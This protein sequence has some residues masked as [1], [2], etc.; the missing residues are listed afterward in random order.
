MKHVICPICGSICIK[1]GKNK[2]GTQRWYCNK[3][4]SSVTPQIDNSAKQLQIFLNWLFSSKTQKEMP[5][6]GRSF[7]RKTAG[8]W[9]IWPLPPL[10]AERSDV[11]YVDGIYLGRK[12]CVIICCD[13]VHVLGWYLCRYENARAYTAL[14]SRIAEPVVVISDG[15]TGFYKAYK[16]AWPHA[17]LQRC[18]FHVFNQ[19]KRYTTSRPNTNAGNDLYLLAKDLFQLKK[20]SDA[21]VWVDNYV[22]W[23]QYYNQFLSQR[24]YDEYGNSRPTHE[25]LIKASRSLSKLIKEGTMFTYLDNE[26]RAELGKIPS[27]NNRIEGGVNAQLRTMLRAHRGLSIER[28]IKAVFWWC[29]MHSPK[30]LSSAEIINTMPTEKSIAEIY[31]RLT[32]QQRLSGSIPNWGDAVVWNEFHKSTQYPNSWD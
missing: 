15:G 23:L 26:L 2:S 32:K 10:V 9:E 6:S 20:M 5:G 1:Y 28:R 29:Y 21:D 3:C 16:K 4:K 25:R 30:P 11:V 31:S 18:I 7:R 14:L 22:R 17:K 13:D 8:F 19:V 27:T 24:T 12:A